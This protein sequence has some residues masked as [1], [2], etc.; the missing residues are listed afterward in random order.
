MP[1][2]LDEFLA[3][4]LSRDREKR[5]DSAQS[6]AAAL[7]AW[8]GGGLAVRVAEVR[9]GDGRDPA[10]DDGE[11]ANRSLSELLQGE[12]VARPADTPTT[13]APASAS[14]Q[15]RRWVTRRMA[16]LVGMAAVLVGILFGVTILLKTPDG[17]LKIES[18]ADNVAV[19]LVD[20]RDQPKVLQIHVGENEATLR[21]GKYRVR[22]S[23][24]HDGVSLDQNEFTLQRDQK[25][26]ARIRYVKQGAGASKSEQATAG[27]PLYQGKRESEWQRV[28]DAE[29]SPVAKLEAAE[30]LLALS[31]GQ[32]PDAQVKRMLDVGE[33]IARASFGEDAID[34]A[35][36][37]R[38][39]PPLNATRWTF[40]KPAR[41]WSPLLRGGV[42]I[43]PPPVSTANETTDRGTEAYRAYDRFQKFLTDELRGIPAKPLAEGLAAALKSGPAPREAFAALLLRGLGRQFIDTDSEATLVVL[44][45]LDGPVTGID[46]SAVRLVV[47]SWYLEH[48]SADQ[49]GSI[50]SRLNRLA[51]LLQEAAPSTT[52]N[53]LTDDL[54]SVLAQ[55]DLPEWPTGLRYRA[56]SLILERI[57]R[58]NEAPPD[59]AWLTNPGAEN[60]GLIEKAY[61]SQT[62]KNGKYFLDQWI[63][64]V[65]AYLAEHCAPPYTEADRK[66]NYSLLK[67]LSLFQD[68]DDWPVDKTASLLSDQLSAYYTDD[69][70]TTTD[71]SV[72]DLLPVEP[73]TLLMEIVSVNGQ[74]PDFVRTSHPKVPAVAARMQQF[75]SVVRNRETNL[76]QFQAD[77][78]NPFSELI[79]QDPYEVVKLAV[80]SGHQARTPYAVLTATSTGIGTVWNDFGR[81][82]PIDRLL[83]LRW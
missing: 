42:R 46:W 24:K 64:V 2:E 25:V 7:S 30:A 18:E 56:A 36:A 22:F 16:W 68:G 38:H 8:A 70:K 43:V 67:V 13:A 50:I 52:S 65:N 19:E 33:E 78:A 3:R 29:T 27:E 14:G 66:I 51:V 5:P 83:L 76:Q 63:F 82:Y 53:L 40:R 37:D 6:V 41:P 59:A 34:L 12:P 21:A 44:H 69:P 71:K 9:A 60:T 45:E 61:M 79:S 81:A 15:T 62:R 39:R 75:V 54:L 28:F 4:L 1:P 49:K 57:V 74:I 20:E 35:L 32:S 58:K 26:V 11:L 72:E 73:A 48:A 55:S 23:G 17:T 77:S 47:Q 10:S 80:E 31:A